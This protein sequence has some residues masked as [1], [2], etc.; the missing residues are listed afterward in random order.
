MSFPQRVLAAIRESHSL[1]R[2]STLT[3]IEMA[4]PHL[5]VA[6]LSRLEKLVHSLRFRREQPMRRSAF[7]LAPLQL[8]KPLKPLTTEDGRLEEMLND[9][10]D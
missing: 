10:R 8:G 6:E 2:M 5:D 7:D 4:I 1:K 3:E 9:T